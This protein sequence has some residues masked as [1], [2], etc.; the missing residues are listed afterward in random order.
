MCE[1]R[2]YHQDGTVTENSFVRNSNDSKI[3]SPHNVYQFLHD[4][5]FSLWDFIVDPIPDFGLRAKPCQ[6]NNLHLRY[7]GFPLKE[8]LF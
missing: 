2:T 3:D 6:D 5:R 7:Q 4:F 1:A 8:V